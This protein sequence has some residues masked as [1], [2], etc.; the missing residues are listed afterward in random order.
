[1][2][3]ADLWAQAK[4]GNAQAIAVLMNQQLQPKGIRAKAMMEQGRLKIIFEARV[5]PPEK[6]L[7]AFTQRGLKKLGIRAIDQV[8]IFGKQAHSEATSWQ[9]DFDLFAANELASKPTN[10]FLE[11]PPSGAYS[12]EAANA[13]ASFPESGGSGSFSPNL[14][15][16]PSTSSADMFSKPIIGISSSMNSEWDSPFA[17]ES[18][19]TV[20]TLFTVFWWLGFAILFLL[21]SIGWFFLCAAVVCLAIALYRHASL[22]QEHGL[23]IQPAL[24]VGYCFIPIFSFYWW[25]KAFPGLANENNR[26]MQRHNIPWPRMN[27]Q[28]STILCYLAIIWVLAAILLYIFPFNLIP[29][30]FS[31]AHLVTVIK[32]SL[33]YIIVEVI[34]IPILIIGFLVEENRKN[35]VLAIINYRQ[36]YGNSMVSA[37][38]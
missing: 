1:M 26:Y 4:Q 9:N 34:K 3:Q 8:S 35:C 14:T 24:L 33:G 21:P 29:L 15:A 6:P 23:T 17:P 18:V 10:S 13:Q 22:L 5:V 38:N 32:D 20:F 31:G 12:T 27:R 30:N 25:F 19:T 2:S 36:L 37:A 28:L 7:V 11:T 16:R